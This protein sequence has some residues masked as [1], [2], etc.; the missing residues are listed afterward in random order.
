MEFGLNKSDIVEIEKVL[1]VKIEI[2][3]DGDGDFKGCSWMMSNKNTE[4]SLL[5]KIYNSAE[6]SDEKTGVLVSVQTKYGY[7]ELHDCTKFMI[8]APDEIIF[9]ATNDTQV[10]SIIIGK[11]VTCSMYSNVSK[12]ILGADFSKL[13]PAV[14]LSAMQLSLAESVLS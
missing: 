3:V 1:G 10:S 8:F 9:L 5:C 13:D 2:L 7:F 6:L 11:Q 14:L 12:D 4:Q